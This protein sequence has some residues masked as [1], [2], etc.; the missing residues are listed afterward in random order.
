MLL[1]CICVLFY[2]VVVILKESC[3]RVFI[4]FV[5]LCTYILSF[6]V[7]VIYRS[8]FYF[9]VL[10]DLFFIVLYIAKVLIIF[11]FLFYHSL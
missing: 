5:S 1:F 7:F 10:I 6:F 4:I 8:Q 2:S 3:L 9:F 11:P